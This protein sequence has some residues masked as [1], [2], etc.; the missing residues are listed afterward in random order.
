LVLLNL[1]IKDLKDNYLPE[2]KQIN[3]EHLVEKIESKET[4]EVVNEAYDIQ[5]DL[6]SSVKMLTESLINTTQFNIPQLKNFAK[7]KCI[8]IPIVKEVVNETEIHLKDIFRK[9][10]SEIIDMAEKLSRMIR[11]N[12]FPIGFDINDLG[13]ELENNSKKKKLRQW[14]DRRKGRY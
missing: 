1:F 11:I 5:K 8:P 14:L 10:A 3:Y 13:Y 7:A 9:N 2:V 4:K 12:S 6:G